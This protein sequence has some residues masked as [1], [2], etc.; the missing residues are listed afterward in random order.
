VSMSFICEVGVSMSF[1]C[2]VGVSMS[3]ICE[4]VVSMSFICEVVVSMSFICT[5]HINDQSLSWL[6]TC[7][8]IKAAGQTSFMDTNL[9]S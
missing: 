8:L 4:V 3:F 2:E 7:T 5:S 9:P 1:I 6:S